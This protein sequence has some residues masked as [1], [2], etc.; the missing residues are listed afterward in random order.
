MDLA[1]KHNGVI[2]AH[3]RGGIVQTLDFHF[4]PTT[5]KVEVHFLDLLYQH[6]IPP[7]VP[8]IKPTP[9]N[10]LDIMKSR[11][12]M[13]VTEDDH[14]ENQWPLR[15]PVMLND[16]NPE[17]SQCHQEALSPTTVGKVIQW[18]GS[19]AEMACVAE[20]PKELSIRGSE[21][22]QSKVS[23]ME[24]LLHEDVGHKVP[25]HTLHV[26]SSGGCITHRH[27]TGHCRRCIAWCN[28]NISPPA[29]PPMSATIPWVEFV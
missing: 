1:V 16:S 13:D 10:W 3:K 18:V 26:A 22:L 23:S 8:G 4:P 14:L 15:V 19:I 11:D 17:V 28:H 25:M 21:P 29:P 20:D 9:H 5:T 24:L 2:S 12:S 6:N 27:C 7:D